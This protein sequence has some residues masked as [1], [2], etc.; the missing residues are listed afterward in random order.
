MDKQDCVLI[1]QIHV[2]AEQP[3]NG[4]N[5][6][7]AKQQVRISQR[8]GR[9]IKNPQIC[10]GRLSPENMIP[11]LRNQHRQPAVAR[12]PEEQGAAVHLPEKEPLAYAQQNNRRH[13]V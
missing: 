6:A 5:Q 13:R 2:Q 1:C 10:H 9:R 8:I 3:E 12:I 4:M 7:K 11:V